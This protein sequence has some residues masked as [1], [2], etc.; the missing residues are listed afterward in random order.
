MQ[1]I[2]QTLFYQH[3]HK[4]VCP[5]TTIN[6]LIL[7]TNIMSD[8]ANISIHEF[9]LLR[10]ISLVFITVHFRQAT[11]MHTYEH[12]QVLTYGS[13]LHIAVGI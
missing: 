9:I 12:V 2:L 3:M 5:R 13:N 8:Q 1:Q 6:G 7:K 11:L 10:D 4:I